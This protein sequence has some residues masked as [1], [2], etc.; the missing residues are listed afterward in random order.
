[1]GFSE[2]RRI[3]KFLPRLIIKNRITQL[4]GSDQASAIPA[5]LIREPHKYF[6]QVVITVRSGDG[7]HGAVLS[8]PS[9][10]APS[11]SP[12]KADQ[13]Q[14]RKK[15]SYKRDSDGSVILPMGG[16]GGDVVIFVDESKDS[17]L[18]LHS[19]NRYNA[20]RGGNV[21]A[22][23]VLTSQLHDGAAAPTLRIPV[24]VGL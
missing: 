24:P 9:A 14:T 20:K 4:K 23:G 12:G 3:L 11:K 22:M 13:S 6:D 2:S 1:M 19:K 8:M 15:S 7:G 5:S 21:D 18:E 17:L 16:H 10:R